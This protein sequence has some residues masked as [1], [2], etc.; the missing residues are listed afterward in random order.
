M[1]ND[2]ASNEKDAYAVFDMFKVVNVIC[3]ARPTS[4]DSALALMNTLEV[5]E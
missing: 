3:D 5:M 1:K 4:L 2:S